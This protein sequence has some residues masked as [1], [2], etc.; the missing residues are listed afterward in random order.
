[1]I[2]K[3]VWLLLV[4]S[5]LVLG[6]HGMKEGCHCCGESD[7]WITI[8]DGTKGL[9]GWK[10]SE[11]KGTFTVQDG[12]LV[13]HGARSHLFYVGPVNGANFK[14][15]EMKVDVK[16]TKGSNAGIYFHTEYQETGWPKKGYEVQVNATHKDKKKGG[17]L[18]SVVDLNPAPVGDDEWYTQHIIV[19]DKHIT[20]LVNG[21][22]EVD[23][24]EPPEIGNNPELG[25][26]ISNG[27]VAIQGHDPK[28]LVYFKNIRIKPLP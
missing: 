7:G 10:A 11:N 5:V 9:E 22:V 14:N 23:Y 15:F 26:K 27:T 24:E 3:S 17:G 20:L 13:A 8:F 6:C 12:L 4:A 18:Y 16:T 28:S 19:R 25:R 21:K 2:R 1:M